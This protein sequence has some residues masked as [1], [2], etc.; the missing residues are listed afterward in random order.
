MSA[1]YPGRVSLQALVL[2]VLLVASLPLAGPSVIAATGTGP[3][4]D[5]GPQNILLIT[6]DTTRADY[7]SCYGSALLTTPNIDALARRGVRFDAATAVIPLTGPGHASMLTGLY[8]RDHGAIRNG[9][10]VAEDAGS[11]AHRITAIREVNF[12]CLHAD[13]PV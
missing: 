5:Q 3:V 13:S 9:V 2:S 12:N 7:L 1:R 10:P 4:D 8:P 6:V 11:D